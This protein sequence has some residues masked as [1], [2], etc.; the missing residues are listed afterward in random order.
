MQYYPNIHHRRSIRLA[1]YDYSQ[2][3]AY[4]VTISTQNHIELFGE[5]L[6]EKMILSNFGK[7][8]DQTWHD[9]PKHYPH[10]E[11]GNHC[12]M[13][14]HVHAILILHESDQ[15]SKISST[16]NTSKTH[17]KV[18]ASHPLSEIIRAFK[19]FSARHINILRKTP[20]IAVWQRNYFEHIIRDPEDYDRI[21]R[22]IESN[23]ANWTKINNG[24]IW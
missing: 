12:I 23:P 17:L 6:N 5:I 18:K 2:P 8:V 13:P 22:Y 14:N 1:G 16:P 3:G 4:Y 15:I 9:L 24:E 10:L 7:I 11:L 20:G 19:S 21:H